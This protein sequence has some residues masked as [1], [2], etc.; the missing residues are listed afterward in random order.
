MFQDE[1]NCLA[2]VREA[3]F[4]SPALSIRAWQFGAVRHK[5]RPI[6][7]DDA[8]ELVAHDS[9]YAERPACKSPRLMT[10]SCHPR[11]TSAGRQVFPAAR[12]LRS[13]P[14]AEC[15]LTEYGKI[16]A[17]IVKPDP[18]V[19]AT[20]LEMILH[21]APV[22]WFTAHCQG[23]RDECGVN[24]GQ[25]RSR[26]TSLPESE[27]ATIRLCGLLLPS[28]LREMASEESSGVCRQRPDRPIRSFG[29]V[30]SR[31]TTLGW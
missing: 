19:L 2:Q 26:N 30:G 14:Q 20:V 21:G 3:L 4:L 25:D 31:L 23:I 8:R 16:Q 1:R 22:L 10:G 9:F 7:L 13:R 28:S 18:S 6:L 5:P 11:L 24:A 29:G 27:T 15:R 12:I 17:L